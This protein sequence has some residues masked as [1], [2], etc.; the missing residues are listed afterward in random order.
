[1]ANLL[2]H[3]PRILVV[4]DMTQKACRDKLVG[5][6]RYAC[7]HGPWDIQRYT[8]NLY[9]A[10]LGRFKNWQPDGIIF[11]G[12]ISWRKNVRC[13]MGRLPDSVVQ[14]EIPTFRRY[15]IVSHDSKL[16][17]EVAADHLLQLDLTN[18]AFVGSLLPTFWS[19]MR[20]E[21]FVARLAAAGHTCHLYAPVHPE[22][23]G[24]EQRHMQAW[25]LALPKPCG[26]LVAH[27]PYAK[28]VLDTCLAAGIRVPDDIAVVGVDNDTDIC[29]GTVPTLTSVFPDFEGG[30]YL[31]AELLDSLLRDTWDGSRRITYGIR[32]VIQR[33]SSMRLKT[34]DRLIAAAVE[35]IRLNA[36]SGITVPDVAAYL[37]VSRRYAE[38]HFRAALGHSILDE[39]QVR[40]LDRVRALLRETNQPI[41]QIGEDCGYDSETYLKALFKRRFGM[42][43]RDYR[44]SR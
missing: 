16:I 17:A 21:V 14:F 13:L 24:L 1:M 15:P 18:F 40:R 6:M 31:A 27:D 5:I 2:Q 11:D 19:Q 33:Q 41:R 42:T 43:M 30:G 25:L 38:R 9:I 28:Q 36:C 12:E 20:E 4:M 39:I 29:E 34:P 23:W 35:Y 37:N 10:Q 3:I 8:N 44:K 32:G 22:D 26:I 7:H